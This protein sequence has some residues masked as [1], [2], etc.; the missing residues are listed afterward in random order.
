VRVLL[1]TGERTLKR[2]SSQPVG[3]LWGC[4]RCPSRTFDAITARAHHNA[5]GHETYL[6]LGVQEEPKG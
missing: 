6:I 4:R 2:I 1:S 5:T 3:T